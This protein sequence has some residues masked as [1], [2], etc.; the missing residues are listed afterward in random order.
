MKIN[1]IS[2]LLILATSLLAG[3]VGTGPNTQ[4]GAVEGGALGAIA[5]GIIGAN[6]RGHN[7]LGG[8]LLGGTLGAIAGGTIGNTIDHDNGTIYNSPDA[9]YTRV[10]YVNE[11]PPAPYPRT[12]IAP[13]CPGPDYIWIDGYWSWDDNCY[14]W[15]PGVWVIGRAGYLYARPHWEYRDGGHVFV[16]GYWHRR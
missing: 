1:K 9:A 4:Q 8:A 14:I 3:C 15:I 10:V 11:V 12:E 16:R 7:V 6:S 2:L 13:I 5:G